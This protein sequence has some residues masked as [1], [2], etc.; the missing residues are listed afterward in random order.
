MNRNFLAPYSHVYHFPSFPPVLIRLIACGVMMRP[1]VEANIS[2]KSYTTIKYFLKMWSSVSETL[3]FI[4]LGVSTV[5]GPHA[6]NWTFVIFTVIICLVSRVLGVIGLTYVINKFRIVK[7]TKK[8]QFI[9]AYGGLRGAIAFSLGFLLTNSKL[10]NMF[11]TA[12]ITVIFFT[13]FV[14]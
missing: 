5:A 7:L 11:L 1:Y 14:Q 3:I 2:H 10:K 6:W 12:I 4:F 9:V 13:V 8:D